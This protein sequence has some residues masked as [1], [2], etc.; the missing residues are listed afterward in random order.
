M[1]SLACDKSCSTKEL[2]KREPLSQAHRR[3]LKVELIRE[4]LC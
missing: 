3:P 2:S 4:N 1:T